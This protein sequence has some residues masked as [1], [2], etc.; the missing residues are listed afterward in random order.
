[1]PAD[2]HIQ[3]SARALIRHYGSGT[4]EALER[5]VRSLET[6]GQAA[7]AEF[8]SGVGVAVK[9]VLKGHRNDTERRV[10]F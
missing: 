9:V 7:D 4:P 6:H 1:M 3:E 5:V 8:W 2:P 10:G